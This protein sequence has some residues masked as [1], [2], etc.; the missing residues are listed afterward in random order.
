MIIN[1]IGIVIYS[2]HTLCERAF[3][4]AVNQSEH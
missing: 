1:F 4:T 2:Y 3:T